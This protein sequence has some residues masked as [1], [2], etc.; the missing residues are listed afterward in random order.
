MNWEDIDKEYASL[1]DYRGD[2]DMYKLSKAVKHGDLVSKRGGKLIRL[3][4]RAKILGVWT[5]PTEKV[6]MT[7]DGKM[8]TRTEPAGVQVY[9]I[10]T[11]K[12][13]R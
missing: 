6:W 2:R 4:R 3:G 12:I 1:K 8:T 11:V 10:A 13:G 9:G 7:L 5:G